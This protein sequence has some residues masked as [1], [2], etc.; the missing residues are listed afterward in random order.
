MSYIDAY[1]DRKN[2]TIAVWEKLEKGKGKTKYYTPEYVLYY[3]DENGIYK[4]MWNKNCSKRTFSNQQKFNA[5][6]NKLTS[7]NITI[8]ESDIPV[9]FRCLDNNYNNDKLPHLNICFFDIE[10]D[11]HEVK[12]FAPPEN[13]FNRVTTIAMYTS[14][15]KKLYTFVL[16]P[17]VPVVD[18]R[19]L[20]FEKADEI[21]SEF[22]NCFLCESEEQLFECFFEVLEDSD[23]D[24]LS[25]WNSMLYDIPYLVNRCKRILPDMVTRFGRWDTQPEKKKVVSFGKDHESYEIKGRVHMDYL[26]LYKKHN[27]KEQHSYKLDY[28]GAIE[29]GE[30]KV[31]YDGNLDMLYKGDFKTFISYAR[32]DVMLLVKIDSKKQY[33]QLS[34]QISHRDRVLFPTTL[35]SVALVEQAITHKVHSIGMVVPTK[36]RQNNNNDT[37]DDDEEEIIDVSSDADGYEKGDKKEDLPAIGAYVAKPKTGLFKFIG[38]V[39][40]NSL[41]PSVI[42]ALNMSIETVFGQARTKYTDAFVSERLKEVKAQ[43]VWNDVFSCVEY[44]LIMEKTSD[45]I[46]FDFIDGNSIEMSAKEWYDIFFAEDSDYILSANATI[47]RKDVE[48]VI[49]KLLADW[50]SERKRLRKKS[51]IYGKLQRGILINEKMLSILKGE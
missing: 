42:R 16:K 3:E 9:I 51:E 48:G 45:P 7:Q 19:Y 22:E 44:K 32:Q 38:C 10:T 36:K 15:N 24:I 43:Y 11:F 25:G 37:T 12:G 26:L 40:I 31:A 41:Y 33:I 27:T 5:E 30:K 23:V 49:P 2:N 21:C 14:D 8:H 13:P 18:K 35:G 28:I 47:F 4:T 6:V 20:S 50:Y 39:D 1:H 46:I 34:S 17:D 29:T